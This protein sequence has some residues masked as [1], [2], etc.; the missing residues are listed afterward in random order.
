MD[1]I[2][3]QLGLLPKRQDDSPFVHQ[4]RS[5]VPAEIRAFLSV[6][7]EVLDGRHA[8]APLLEKLH[9]LSQAFVDTETAVWIL[10]WIRLNYFEWV[11]ATVAPQPFLIGFA[12][13]SVSIPLA[14]LYQ[15]HPIRSLLAKL[16][17]LFSHKPYRQQP[18]GVTRGQYILARL[19]AFSVL[20]VCFYVAPKVTGALLAGTPLHPLHWA[21]FTLSASTAALLGLASS[22]RLLEAL[23]PERPAVDEA[24]EAIN[25]ITDNVN[26]LVVSMQDP[27]QAQRVQDNRRVKSQLGRIWLQVRSIFTL[28]RHITPLQRAIGI[29]LRSPSFYANDPLK[30]FTAEANSIIGNWGMVGMGVFLY[31]RLLSYQGYKLPTD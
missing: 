27:N 22:V 30:V 10:D 17:Q 5:L 16:E 23:V 26:L 12:V 4:I 2:A 19:A 3:Q 1:A 24:L 29:G 11:C 14:R 28:L 20:P 9:V 6:C 25:N 21:S 15:P 13:G 8:A 7:F 18:L 31:L